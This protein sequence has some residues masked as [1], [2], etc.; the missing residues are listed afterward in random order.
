[1]NAKTTT[2]PS[3]EYPKM[4][5]GHMLDY[6]TV[7]SLDEERAASGWV[8]HPIKVAQRRRR[9]QL[10]L[11]SLLFAHRHWQ[12]W[13]TTAIAAAAVYAAWPSSK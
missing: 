4:L 5:Y 13:I 3:T 11:A 6:K 9:K 2:P 10:L 7:S 8:D 12:F 1:M